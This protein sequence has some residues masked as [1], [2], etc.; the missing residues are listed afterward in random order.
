MKYL[1]AILIISFF[2]IQIYA[3][4]VVFAGLSLRFENSALGVNAGFKKE[5]ADFGVGGLA[6]ISSYP[7]KK[8]ENKNHDEFYRTYTGLVLGGYYNFYLPKQIIIY[9]IA[10]MVINTTRYKY[11]IEN[12]VNINSDE[13]SVSLT[14]IALGG[15][16]G[17][18]LMKK[19]G[20]INLIGNLRQEFSEY[21]S[22]K[23]F[24]GLAYK[25]GNSP[26][27]EQ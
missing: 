1:A 10:G 3:Q 22:V 25:F 21:G 11:K 15:V 20:N 8:E 17:I 18:G 2:P 12:S 6:E 19:M 24:V 4:D 26:N 13:F 5:I 9:P 14:D 27:D 23:L 16:W 7:H